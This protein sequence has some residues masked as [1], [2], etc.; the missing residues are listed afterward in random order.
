MDLGELKSTFVNRSQNNVSHSDGLVGEVNSIYFD[1][2]T[3]AAAGAI[4]TVKSLY[5]GLQG[6]GSN[7]IPSVASDGDDIAANSGRYG[8]TIPSTVGLQ[9][10]NNPVVGTI[11]TNADCRNSASRFCGPSNSVAKEV[12]NSNGQP[13]DSARVQMD[14]AASASGSNSP[15]TYT[16]TLTFIATAT[17]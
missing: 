17:F 15:G 3:N 9:N 8:F 12:F 7:I 11:I 1:L 14:I 13:I 4:V 16:D 2:T 6:P 5:G 10:P